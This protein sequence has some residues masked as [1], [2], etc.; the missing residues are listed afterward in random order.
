LG[1]SPWRGSKSGDFVGHL[2][3][4]FPPETCGND[5]LDFKLSVASLLHWFDYLARLIKSFFDTGH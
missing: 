1:T 4:G 5:G 2:N 3:I